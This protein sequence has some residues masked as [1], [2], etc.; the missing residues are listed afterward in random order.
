MKCSAF[1]QAWS[2][3]SNAGQAG[4]FTHCWGGG[5]GISL[6]P[7]ETPLIQEGWEGAGERSATQ[8]SPLRSSL[9]SWVAPGSSG[10]L[11]GLGKCLWESSSR[12]SPE[13]AAR[14]SAGPLGPSSK[15]PQQQRGARQALGEPGPLAAT[16]K[17]GHLSRQG[18]RVCS[19]RAFCF[20][21]V[22][23]HGVDNGERTETHLQNSVSVEMIIST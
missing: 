16:S 1:L 5:R 14:D 17:L 9:L 7:E 21:G 18:A 19:R 6:I 3:A 4:L 2:T 20:R 23:K 10:D 13:I 8:A 15:G 22:F 11:Q 12:D